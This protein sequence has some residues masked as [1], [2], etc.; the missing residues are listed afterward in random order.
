VA[1]EHE[2]EHEGESSEELDAEREALRLIALAQIRQYPDPVLRMQ[3]REVE[4]FDDELVRLVERMTM[5]MEGANG[6]GLAATQIGV[7]RR[8][9]VLRPGDESPPVALINPVLTERS[10]ELEV[11]DEGCLSLQGIL[12]PVER[13]VAVKVTGKDTTGEVVELSLEGFPARAAQH[14]V[15][16]LDGVLILDRTTDEARRAA[17]AQLRPRPVLGARA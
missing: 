4:S 16:H 5:L 13:A 7:L 17:I 9:F 11:D 12:V 8:V 3:A 14:E 1:G 15:D 6:A 10:E 2:H